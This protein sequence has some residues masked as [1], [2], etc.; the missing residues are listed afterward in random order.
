MPLDNTPVSYTV[1]KWIVTETYRAFQQ[2]RARE[3]GNIMFGVKD[4]LNEI[5]L[6]LEQAFLLYNQYQPTDHYT[7]RVEPEARKPETQPEEEPRTTTHDY[8]NSNETV[9]DPTTHWVVPWAIAMD[10]AFGNNKNLLPKDSGCIARMQ[11]PRDRSARSPK[12]IVWL[13]DICRKFSFDVP[14]VYWI[15]WN[16]L[17][18]E[19]QAQALSHN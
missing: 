11:E 4:K 1:L 6:T 8:L 19:D 2:S 12:E 17:S 14:D 5:G 18:A 10:Q 9:P 15:W 13:K 3:C 7:Q 16:S